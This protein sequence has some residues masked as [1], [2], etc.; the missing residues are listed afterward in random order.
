MSLIS[1]ICHWYLALEAFAVAFDFFRLI[2][3]PSPVVSFAFKTRRFENQ[4][5]PS[6]WFF[7]RWIFFWK[8]RRT[9]KLTNFTI[10]FIGTSLKRRK[11]ILQSFF[12]FTLIG[13]PVQCKAC[14]KR[15]FFPLS[16]SKAD[17]NSNFESENACPK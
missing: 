15:T 8:V 9:T 13:I 10:Q 5:P 12:G 7:R 11:L 6:Y 3:T 4:S 16:L 14:G 1:R 17:R 2:L